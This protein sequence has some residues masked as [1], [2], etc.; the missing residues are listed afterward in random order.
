MKIQ[1]IGLNLKIGATKTKDVTSPRLVA[2]P[3]DQLSIS[4]D[5]KRLQPKQG[6]NQTYGSSSTS[7]SPQI[8]L[9]N[10]VYSRQKIQASKVTDLK[11]PASRDITSL[12][13]DKT[14]SASADVRQ[15]KIKEAKLKLAQ[16]YYSRAE[17]YS[18]VAER[19]L[20]ILI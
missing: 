6:I 14:V 10:S 7:G 20:D 5:A 17:V 15:E 2:P 3:G 19:I 11:K 9:L 1:K 13:S 4:K 8:N 18:K 16:G 12:E